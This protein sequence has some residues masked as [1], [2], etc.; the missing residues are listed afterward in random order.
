MHK[1]NTSLLLLLMGVF[2]FLSGCAVTMPSSENM[3]FREEQPARADRDVPGLFPKPY[4]KQYEPGDRRIS[5]GLVSVSGRTVLSNELSYAKDKFARY[6]EEKKQEPGIQDED[7]MVPNTHNTAV[8]LPVFLGRSSN[9]A[10]AGSV[11][12]P[13]LGIDLTTK[14]FDDTFITANIHY[15]SGELIVQRKVLQNDKIGIAVG[16]HFRIQR[17]WLQVIEGPDESFG[18]STIISAL[19]PE[20]TFYNSTVGA[21]ASLHIPVSE[22]MYLHGVVAPGYVTNHQQVTL[23]FGL[24]LQYYPW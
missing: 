15:L 4:Q 16:P 5:V 14:L 19:S 1:F 22:K 9:V 2:A 21:R 12:L 7:F 23:N 8:S 6:V 20:K 10:W 17:R 24:S 3:M 18:I 11:G 13:V